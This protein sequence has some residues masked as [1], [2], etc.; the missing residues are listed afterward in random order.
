MRA[1]R[2]AGTAWASSKTPGPAIWARAARS[3][4]PFTRTRPAVGLSRPAITH[5]VTGFL[6][7]PGAGKPTTTR[8]IAGLDEP[9]AGRVKVNGREHRAAPAPM[10]GLGVVLEATAMH[11]GRPA[12]NHL[13]RVGARPRQ[14][15]RSLG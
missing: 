3:S 6:G 13:L 2:P 11:P 15:V 5:I 9:T 1:G 10:A 8:L 7:P 12:R 4:R 14:P